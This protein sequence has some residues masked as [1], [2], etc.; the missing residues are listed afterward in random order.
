MMEKNHRMRENKNH[1][2]RENKGCGRKIR[3]RWNLQ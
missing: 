2:K 3:A 1:R